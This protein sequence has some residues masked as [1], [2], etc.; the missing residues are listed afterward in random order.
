MSCRFSLRYFDREQ[1]EAANVVAPR[2]KMS[3]RHT[4]LLGLRRRQRI[5]HLNSHLLHACLALSQGLGF[6]H[7][8]SNGRIV[9]LGTSIHENRFIITPPVLMDPSIPYLIGPPNTAL[10]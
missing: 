8:L 10:V 7:L 4:C 5:F 1:V 6:H 2:L 9:N 3:E